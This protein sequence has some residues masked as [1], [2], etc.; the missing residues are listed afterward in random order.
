MHAATPD[1]QFSLQMVL[2]YLA[3]CAIAAVVILVVRWWRRHAVPQGLRKRRYA[4]R[5][6][7]RFQKTRMQ[8]PKAQPVSKRG[9]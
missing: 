3:L 1:L 2:M 8:R 9:K 7:A 5:L 4:V 6:A